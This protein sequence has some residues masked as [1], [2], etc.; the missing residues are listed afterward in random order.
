MKIELNKYIVDESTSILEIMRKI[1]LNARGIVYICEN[2]YLLGVITDGDIRRYI[3]KHNTL[4]SHANLIMNK[5]PKYFLN[6]DISDVNKY[7]KDNSIKSVPI[8]DE[9]KKLQDIV[10]LEGVKKNKEKLDIPVVIMAG[11]KGSRLFPYTKVLPKPLIPVN[12]KTITELIME[13]FEE[14][15]CKEF[16][17]IVNYKKDF[18]KAFFHDTDVHR[19]LTFI[20]ED[21]YMGTA[22]GLK[23][24][25]GIIDKTFFLSNCDILIEDNYSSVLEYHKTNKNIITI[26][27]AL[28]E[29]IFPY[30]TVQTDE[31]GKAISLTE[32]PTFKFLTNTGFYIVEPKFM[33]FIPK[34]TFIHITDVIQT[35]MNSGENVGVYPVCEDSWMDMGQLDELEKMKKKLGGANEI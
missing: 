2:D 30:G 4:N 25:N 13:H 17:M 11:G 21:S 1:D 8:I 22:G 24:L 6:S 34:N 5:K 28:K 29:E 7:M 32:K 31:N 18:I 26:V 33:D 27:C 14:Y 15:D 16:F 9:N 12:D 20:D 3:L 35:C 23:L 19:K 10:F